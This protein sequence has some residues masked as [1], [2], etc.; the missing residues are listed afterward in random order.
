[1][2]S[3][4]EYKAPCFLAVSIKGK[5]NEFQGLHDL[6]VMFNKTGN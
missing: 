6:L 2:A 4:G 1:M 5:L 3:G